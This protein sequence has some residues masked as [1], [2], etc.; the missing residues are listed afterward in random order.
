[1]RLLRHWST[2]EIDDIASKIERLVAD[3]RRPD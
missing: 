2:E 3:L 1:V